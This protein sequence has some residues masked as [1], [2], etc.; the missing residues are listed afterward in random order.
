M[1]AEDGLAQGLAPGKSGGE[2]CH[3]FLGGGFLPLE[4]QVPG[5][6]QGLVRGVPEVQAVLI[7]KVL[8]HRG[9]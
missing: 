4:L 6:Q 3:L 5:V 1:A 8:D 7:D 9:D 2:L